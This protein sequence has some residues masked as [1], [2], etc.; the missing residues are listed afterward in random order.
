MTDLVKTR[1]VA[2]MIKDL[3]NKGIPIHGVG[4]QGH[5]HLEWPKDSELR[6]ALNILSDIDVKIS[7]SE[8]DLRVLPHPKE[9]EMG[10][11]IKLNVKRLKS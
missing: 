8:L 6:E 7:I 9:T 1:F 2:E 3:K 11:D 5:W 10:A 4:M